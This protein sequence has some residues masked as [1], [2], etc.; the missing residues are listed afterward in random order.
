MEERIIVF[1][2]FNEKKDFFIKTNAPKKEIEKALQFK[3]ITKEEKN[4]NLCDFE[5]I[6]KRLTDKG[7]SI[8]E[9]NLEE[10]YF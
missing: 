10:D 3:D 2:N 1:K 5:I 8:C 6:E 7:Y 9:I 4:V